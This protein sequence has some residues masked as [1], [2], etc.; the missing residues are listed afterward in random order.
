MNLMWFMCRIRGSICAAHVC[1]Q[2]RCVK[3]CVSV[4]WTPRVQL[5][6]SNNWPAVN[7]K[8]STKTIVNVKKVN[9]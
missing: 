9:S 7:N 4:Q 3:Y 5:L 1:S 6:E 8:K 2:G